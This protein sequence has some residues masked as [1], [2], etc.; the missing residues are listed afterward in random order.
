MSGSNSSDA[1]FAQAASVVPE[2]GG[3]QPLG[4]TVH[5]LPQAGDAMAA[6]QPTAFYQLVYGAA[7]RVAI[8]LKTLGKLLF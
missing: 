3:Q 1:S 5:S 8:D 4:L 6:L 7:Q 2:T